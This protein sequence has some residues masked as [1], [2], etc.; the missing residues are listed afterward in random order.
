MIF[1]GRTSCHGSPLF[2]LG[3]TGDVGRD[4]A[5]EVLDD[6][7]GVVVAMGRV[8]KNNIQ[9]LNVYIL[10]QHVRWSYQ[11]PIQPRKREQNSREENA[12]IVS[13]IC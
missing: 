9:V 7:V 2:M 3:R 12:R 5:D 6:L 13:N 11:D 4:S 10:R 8:T 1:S